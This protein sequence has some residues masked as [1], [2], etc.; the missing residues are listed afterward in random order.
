MA[1]ATAVRV[2]TIVGHAVSVSV[3]LDR[4]MEPQEAH[5][6]LASFPGV[7]VLDRPDAAEYPTPQAAAG[8]DETLVGRIRRNPAIPNGLSLFVAQDNLRKG[9]AL[10]NV[11]IAEALLGG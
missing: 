5:E 4:A 3:S 10:N 6:A 1:H 7:R 9:A 8:L 2:P 11:Q